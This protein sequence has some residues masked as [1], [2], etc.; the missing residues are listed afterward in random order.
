MVWREVETVMDDPRS[1]V[2]DTIRIV[3]KMQKELFQKTDRRLVLGLGLQWLLAVCC[4][5]IGMYVNWYGGEKLAPAD[6]TIA[7]LGGWIVVGL[8]ISVWMLRP[9]T[10]QSRLAIGI[11][12]ALLAGILA[13]VCPTPGSALIY[14]IAALA[15]LATYRNKTVLNVATGVM[16]V[17]HFARGILMPESQ[18]GILAINGVAAATHSG[19]LAA[20]LISV[21]LLVRKQ[22]ADMTGLANRDAQLEILYQTAVESESSAKASF[23]QAAVGMCYAS[24]TGNIIRINCQFCEITGYSPLDVAGW[25]LSDITHPED[26][27]R[28]NEYARKLAD[29]ELYHYS[30]E[31]RYI[32][33]DGH[34]VWVS[35]SV[36]L[37]RCEQGPTQNYQMVVVRDISDA[38]ND[39]QKASEYHEQVQKLSLVASKTKNPVLILDADGCTEWANSAFATL[40]EYELDEIISRRPSELLGGPGT[41]LGLASRIDAKINRGEPVNE[42]L[43]YYSKSRRPF[44]ADIEIHPVHDEAGVLTN[45]IVTYSDITERLRYTQQLLKAK[46]SAEAASRAM[47]KA[48]STAEKAN[49]SKS[50]FLANMSHEIRT[51]LNG[52]IGFSELLVTTPDLEPDEAESHLHTIRNSGRH[53]LALVNDILDLSKIE[54]SKMELETAAFSPHHLLAEVISLA[55]IQAS[56]KSLELN[57]Q[58]AT[59]VPKT[60]KGDQARLRQVLLNLLG[61]AI[62]FTESGSVKVVASVT[63][64]SC[65]EALMAFAVEDTG[66]GIGADNLDKIFRPFS[67]EDETVTRRFGGTGLGLTISKR[68][69]EL[70]GGDLT[71]ESKPGEGSTFK[72][73]FPA[74]KFDQI[75]LQPKPTHEIEVRKQDQATNQWDLSHCHVLLVDDGDTN[76][77]LVKIILERAGATIDEAENGLVACNKSRETDYDVVLLDMQMPVMDGYTAASQMRDDGFDKPII[78]LTAHAMRSDQEKCLSAGCSEYLTKP[79]SRTDLLN[80]LAEVV[81]VP[82]PTHSPDSTPT[83]ESSPKEKDTH[84]VAPTP[85]TSSPRLTPASTEAIDQPLPLE[86]SYAC[87]LPTDDAEIREVVVEFVDALPAR[88]EKMQA[89]IESEDTEQLRSLAHWLKGAGGTVGFDCFTQPAAKLEALAKPGANPVAL[90]AYVAALSGITKKLVV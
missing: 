66:I 13:Q 75:K 1:T 86:D 84:P 61:N 35:V 43:L 54:S 45:L 19:W 31:E 89:A 71:V 57:F 44:W 7:A 52:I 3:H 20:A 72:L 17:D 55:R 21:H 9:G 60:I 23:E 30:L 5:C 79:L 4:A 80:K 64:G 76:R 11:A 27:E 8:A 65:G 36:S 87:D 42:E 48:K 26:R 78:A 77:R 22:Q 33:K 58:W 50:Q 38:K 37:V 59:D 46:S 47:L 32:H 25:K 67:Q 29:A 18:F 2:Q 14:A 70:L 68:I 15:L 49:S 10:T 40:T 73:R 81:P 16:L 12:Q 62:K 85:D 56:Q 53:L 24:T 63:K 69:A 34:Y 74:G 28:Q 39:R 41:D 88:I 6:A 51:P 82:P 83:S 90:E